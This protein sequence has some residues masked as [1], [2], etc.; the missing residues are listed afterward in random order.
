MDAP[1]PDTTASVSPDEGDAQGAPDTLTDNQRADILSAVDRANAVWVE[2]L[3]T[4]DSS[5]LSA[6][7]AGQL[8]DVDMAEVDQLRRMGQTMKN[9]NSAFMVASVT[10]D[11][12]GHAVVRTSEAWYTETYDGA[13]GGLLERSPL[14]TY[15]ETYTVEYLSG[16][17]I[18]TRNVLQAARSR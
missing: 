18:V 10:L 2:A 11:A 9:I 14:A 12:P 5:V 13:T 8:L 6:G 15:A 7:V 16:A 1:A 3:Q 4:Q 17:W